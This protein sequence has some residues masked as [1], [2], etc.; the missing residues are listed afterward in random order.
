MLGD[1]LDR[2]VAGGE[3]PR[4]AA[5]RERDEHELRARGRL[6]DRHQRGVA[7]LR[8]DERKDALRERDEQREY[9][10]EV[11]EFW[12]HFASFSVDIDIA[13]SLCALSTAAAAS[14]GM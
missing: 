12:N 10:C 4:E 1:Q 9:Q 14:G 13:L 5:E 6:G 2:E 11:A 3:A 7:P 8:T